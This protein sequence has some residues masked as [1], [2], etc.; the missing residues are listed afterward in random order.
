MTTARDYADG[1]EIFGASETATFNCVGT[2][3]F[4]LIALLLVIAAYFSPH[5]WH[6]G[7]A[8]EALVIQDIVNHHRWLLP[9]RN[10]EL[11]SKPPL[12]HWMAATFA[13][14]MGVSDFTVRLPSIVG[15]ALL[16]W[17]TY[18]IG[19][20][21]ANRQTGLLA[22]GFL[23]A[24]FEFWDSGTEARVDMLFAALVAAALAAWYFWYLSRRE[25]A[26]GMAYVAVALAVLTKGPAGAALPGIVILSFLLFKRDVG[27]LGKFFSWSWALLVLMLDLGWYWAAYQRGGVEFWHKQI[28]YENVNRFFGAAEF[29]TRRNPFSQVV[30]LITQLFPWNLA[31]V[32]AS[33][34]W[35]RRRREDSFGHFLHAWW[36]TIFAFFLSAAGQRGV[37]LLPIYPAVAL[38]AARECA[39]FLN[40][41]QRNER[42]LWV[43]RSAALAIV[44]AAIDV[45]L[46]IAIPLSRTVQED[47]NE[48]E[49]FVEAVVPKIA[50]APLLYAAPDFPE[51]ALL[52]LAYRLKRNI[53]FQSLPCQGDYYY[54]SSAN[55]VGSCPAQIGR[56]VSSARKRNLRLLYVSNKR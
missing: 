3:A 39:A 27:A 40:D 33:V 32:V 41:R 49:E 15:A 2:G 34:R 42:S 22:V 4:I 10:G 28:I 8:R 9:L 21:G 38:L 48:Q 19:R 14:F 51:T 44:L 7:E 6:H 53:P 50:R 11:P 25:V 12:Y 26:R 35:L 54:F 20:L 5:I 36:L 47:R 24:T 30:W 37:Y 29:H 45:A 55:L 17:I 56:I 1:A 46:A 43:R 31:L 18:S 52:V 23:M 13:S 16:A